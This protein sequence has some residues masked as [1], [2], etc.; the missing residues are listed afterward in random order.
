MCRLHLVGQMGKNTNL[1]IPFLFS[2]VIY[3][4]NY[5]QSPFVCN[6]V[7]SA[8]LKMFPRFPMTHPA[9]ILCSKVEK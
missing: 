2:I 6:I 8:S 5:I 7:M 9:S 4:I 3:V 1:N